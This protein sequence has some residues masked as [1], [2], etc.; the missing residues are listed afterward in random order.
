MTSAVKSE[1]PLEK[2]ESFDELMCRH[3]RSFI[4]SAYE[5]LLG[6]AP[7][8]DG[9]RHYLTRL[10]SGGSKMNIVAS[11]CTSG[12]GHVYDSQLP[13]LVKALRRHRRGTLPF[14]GVVF[15]HLYG[16]EKESHQSRRLGVLESLIGAASVQ[17]EKALSDLIDSLANVEKAVY[18]LSAASSPLLGTTQAATPIPAPHGAIA[19]PVDI[20][21]IPLEVGDIY[22]R[23][24]MAA[25]RKLET[26][27]AH[28][29]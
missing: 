17:R 10:R 26:A 6:R 16:I 2:L 13:G 11:L 5:S 9:F 25:G 28:R 14:A 23:L 12:E 1:L 22:V 29:H 19:F 15:R 20:R 24:K 8:D 3:D 7:D 18:A 21:N 27:N 4:I